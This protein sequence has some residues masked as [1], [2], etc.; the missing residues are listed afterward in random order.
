VDFVLHSRPFF[1]SA[2]DVPN[3]QMRTRIESVTKAIPRADAKWLGRRLSLLSAGQVG[4]GFRAGG[5]T[6]DEITIYTRAVRKR[7][8]QLN[9]L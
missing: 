2:I 9:A 7:I 4:D 6:S 3:Y 5:Y 1:L 8:A